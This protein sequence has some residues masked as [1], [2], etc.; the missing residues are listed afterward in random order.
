MLEGLDLSGIQDEGARQCVLMLLNLIEDLK[1]ENA[2]LRAEVQRLRD[3]NNRL[4]GEQGK[5]NVKPNTRKPPPPAG[6]DYSSE[7][8]RHQPKPWAKS[9]KKVCSQ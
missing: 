8:E 1:Q 4:K 6:T 3:E 5:P 7:R 9:S 2:E